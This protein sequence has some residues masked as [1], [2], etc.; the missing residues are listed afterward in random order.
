ML[1]LRSFLYGGAWAVLGL[2]LGVLSQLACAHAGPAAGESGGQTAEQEIRRVLREAE[3]NEIRR[4]RATAERLLADDFIRT[5]PHGEV[6]DR[7]QTLANFPADDGSKARSVAFEDERIRVYGDAAVVTGLGVLKGADKSG[8]P[9]EV[10][11]RCTFVLVRRDGR[12][13]AAAVHQTRAD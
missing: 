5:G 1:S 7:A 10:R 9:F 11:N 6:W 13:Q 2:A 8:R 12:W 4:D 3:D